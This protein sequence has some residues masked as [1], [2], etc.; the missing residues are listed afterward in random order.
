MAIVL[1]ILMVVS[2]IAIPNMIQVISTSRQRGIMMTVS[3]ILQQ[4]RSQAVRQNKVM[5]LQSTTV[6]TQT[7][8]FVKDVTISSPTLVTSDIQVPLGNNV[9]YIQ[10][11]TGSGGQPAPLTADQMWGSGSITVNT[12]GPVAFNSH[13][14]PCVWNSAT[15]NCATA[16]AGVSPTGFVLYYSYLPPFGGNRWAAMSVS[17]AGRVKAWFWKGSAW[18]N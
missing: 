9:N 7:I 16:A 6:G 5:A 10:N 4:C 12:T 1:A 2:A 17:P 8:Y 3:G 15:Q 18:G 14:V 13:G 11:P